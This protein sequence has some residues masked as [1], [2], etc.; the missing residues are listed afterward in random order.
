MVEILG[1]L[2]LLLVGLFGAYWYGRRRERKQIRESFKESK[3]L[4]EKI[5]REVETQDDKALID[6]IHRS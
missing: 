6:L 5:D 1:S 4:K 2:A 3:Q